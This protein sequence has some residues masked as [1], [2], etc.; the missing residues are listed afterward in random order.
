MSTDGPQDIAQPSLCV[1]DHTDETKLLAGDGE[2]VS[3]QS[4]V[5]IVKREA[6]VVEEG[7]GE[8]GE[9]R[10]ESGEERGEALQ[11]TSV[12]HSN[13]YLSIHL[14]PVK[15]LLLDLRLI[16]WYFRIFSLSP[17]FICACLHVVVVFLSLS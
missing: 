16:F 8:E 1:G 17:V 7:E 2:S 10:R 14:S 9:E 15:N 11:V 6:A 5:A 13:G 3:S 12:T 4:N